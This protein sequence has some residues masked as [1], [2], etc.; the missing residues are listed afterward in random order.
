MKRLVMFAAV[1]LLT[2]MLGGS[3]AHA[4]PAYGAGYGVLHHDI[5][6]DQRDIR[7]D[8]RALRWDAY[9]HDLAAAVR[10]R[11]DIAHD[12]RNIAYNRWIAAQYYGR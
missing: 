1:G 7:Q 12:Y 4:F 11:M 5:R 8:E 6:V 10:E 2:T 3:V 9:H